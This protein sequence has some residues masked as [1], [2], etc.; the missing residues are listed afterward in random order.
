MTETFGFSSFSLRLCKEDATRISEPNE[1]W[2]ILPIQL[3]LLMVLLK[4]AK[5]DDPEVMN[6][7]NRMLAKFIP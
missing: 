7:Y 3:C 1:P 2:S 4:K 5:I 6:F